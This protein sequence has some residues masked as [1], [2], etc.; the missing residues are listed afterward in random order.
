VLLARRDAETTVRTA[1][2]AVPVTFV[3]AST[4]AGATG[5]IVLPELRG[6][7]GREA[8]RILTRLGIVPRV[9]GEGIVIEQDPPPGGPVEPGGACRLVLGRPVPGV[10]P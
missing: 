5:Q 3:P 2:L 9:A 7:G 4:L 10:R 1:A 6:L 8:L